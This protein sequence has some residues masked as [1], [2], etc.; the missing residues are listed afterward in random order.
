MGKCASR[1]FDFLGRILLN[2]YN[3]TNYVLTLVVCLLLCILLKT[4]QS[5]INKVAMRTYAILDATVPSCSVNFRQAE[6]FPILNLQSETAKAIRN[7]SR[8]LVVITISHVTSRIATAAVNS[9]WSSSKRYTHLSTSLECQTNLITLEAFLKRLAVSLFEITGP[10]SESNMFNLRQ[11]EVYHK[12]VAPGN[13]ALK[14]K[15]E[16]TAFCARQL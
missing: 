6:Q 9:T 11:K 16:K 15:Q 13:C 7:C 8:D 2:K 1:H 10:S 5:T 14:E 4:K 3:N 12:N